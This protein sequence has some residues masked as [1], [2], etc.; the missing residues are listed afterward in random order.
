M[1]RKQQLG[2]GICV[3]VL[4]SLVTVAAIILHE[5]QTGCGYKTIDE[6]GKLTDQCTDKPIRWCTSEIEVLLD[7]NAS[8]LKPALVDILEVYQ[9][10]AVSLNAWDDFDRTEGAPPNTIRVSVSEELDPEIDGYTG[11]EVSRFN[12]STGCMINS[13]ITLMDDISWYDEE[14]L[15]CHEFG[16]ALG[17]THSSVATSPMYDPPGGTH[18]RTTERMQNA[19]LL[20]MGYYED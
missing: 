3:A 11:V 20:L 5:K 16:H 17:L 13:H 8:Q 15:L 12:G 7:D 4:V 14:M 2:L 19:L 1:S 10:Y 18:C 6:N 9:P